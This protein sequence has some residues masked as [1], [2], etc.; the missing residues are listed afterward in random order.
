VNATAVLALAA[1]LTFPALAADPPPEPREPRPDFSREIE[2]NKSW[3]IP[4][5]EI[6]AFQFLL[7]RFDNEYFGCCDYAV[8][9]RTIR[10]HLRSSWVVDSDPFLV[11]QFGHPY[12]GSVYH[13]LARSSGHG[14]WTSMGYTFL[15]SALWEVAGET[16]PP[17]RNDQITTGIGGS[18]LGEALYRMA[19]LVL[20]RRSDP[21][22]MREV[23]AALISPPMGFNRVAFGDRFNRVFPGRDPVYFTRFQ[24]GYS[25]T[26]QSSEATSTTKLR[27]NEALVDFYVDYGLPGKRDYEYTRPFDYFNFQATASSANGFENVMTRGLLKGKPYEWGDNYRGV[28]GLY[29]HYDYIA[30]QLFRVS[31][32]AL[33]LGTTAEWRP[34]DA[35]AL[36][37][38]LAGGVGYAAASTVDSSTEND[39]HYGVAPTALLALRA[40]FGDRVALDLTGREYYV[41][42]LAAADRGGHENI[43]R[44]DAALTWRIK[45]RHGISIK[46]LGNRRDARYPEGDRTQRRQTVGIFYTWLGR[47]RFGAYDWEK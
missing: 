17:S 47:D 23:A 35:V 14:F 46:Y 31:S 24:L 9:S 33:T 22:W 7:N 28:F 5:A 8:T 18:F 32:T 26:A 10:D 39:F 4:A 16:T 44:V 11:N 38:T 41:S 21:S 25:G 20:E 19:N 2:E 42:R 37:G 6:V 43:A 27:A 36:Q 3:F 13:G 15:A 45:D 12:Q 34:R 30:P 1:A 29:G 40:V